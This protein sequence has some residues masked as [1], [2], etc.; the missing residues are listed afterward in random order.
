MVL[1][2]VSNF[3]MQAERE[4]L[5]FSGREQALVEGADDRVQP[6]ESS[7]HLVQGRYSG[8]THHGFRMSPCRIGTC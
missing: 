2:I 8:S 7:S 5:R 1:R 4:F 6:G 3:R